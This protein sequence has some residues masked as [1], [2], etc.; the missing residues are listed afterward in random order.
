MTE[1]P[2]G[3]SAG[4]VRLVAMAPLPFVVLM[5]VRGSV[6]ATAG[7]AAPPLLLQDARQVAL[8]LVGMVPPLLF[9]AFLWAPVRGIRGLGYLGYSI[10]LSLGFSIGIVLAIAGWT[11][12]AGATTPRLDGLAW[13]LLVGAF[14]SGACLLAVA[15][16]LVGDWR[17]S[18][19]AADRGL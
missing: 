4:W 12:P 2:G 1:E 19:R 5:A 7:P 8:A 15:A 10:S 6:L 11:A 9:G 16:L 14:L 18:R 17:A 13:V 3:T